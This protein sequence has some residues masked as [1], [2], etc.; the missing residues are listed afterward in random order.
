[1]ILHN[2]LSPIS[3]RQRRLPRQIDFTSCLLL[4]NASSC[5]RLLQSHGTAPHQ[6]SYITLS[7]HLYVTCGNVSCEF[8]SLTLSKLLIRTVRVLWPSVRLTVTEQ[9]TKS[10]NCYQSIFCSRSS[11]FVIIE[12]KQNITNKI[13][14]YKTDILPDE[15]ECTDIGSGERQL[16]FL[17]D[18]GH[19][20]ALEDI[21]N[22]I[23][24]SCS[25][26]M[27]ILFIFIGQQL[28]FDM[29]RIS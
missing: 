17:F 22:R 4:R 16:P 2:S 7:C 15:Q 5:L 23:Q 24:I 8:S 3:G 13:K 21:M 25:Y 20:E 27:I 19:F 28:Q 12:M 10:G 1:M 14:L 26:H 11:G 6:G 29:R 9:E 18:G